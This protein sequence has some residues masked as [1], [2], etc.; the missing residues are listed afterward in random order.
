MWISGG[1]KQRW[2]MGKRWKI[3]EKSYFSLQIISAV[4]FDWTSHGSG[5]MW[6]IV[7]HIKQ[8]A[9]KDWWYKEI[10]KKAPSMSILRGSERPKAFKVGNFQ[11]AKCEGMPKSVCWKITDSKSINNNSHF[12]PIGA[13]FCCFWVRLARHLDELHKIQLQQIQI[14][15]N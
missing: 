4:N 6:E 15:L 2:S 11:S 10:G 14:D 3:G 9:P 12:R 7:F 13:S 1:G 8:N 5:R